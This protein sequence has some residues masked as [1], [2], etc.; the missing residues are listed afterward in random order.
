MRAT[1]PNDELTK[2]IADLQGERR[3]E[4]I[5]VGGLDADDVAR[6]VAARSVDAHANDMFTKTEGNP[7]YVEELVRH[8][9]ESGGVLDDD[10]VPDS[11]RDTIARRLLRLPDEARRLLGI[12]AVCGAEFRNATIA[13]AADVGIDAVDD[14]MEL[15][16]RSGVVEER[17][18]SVGEYG[19]SHTLIQTVLHDGLGAARR[20]R[21]HRRI[22]EALMETG[23][24]DGEIAR[25][26][27]AA[28]ADGSDPVPGTEAALP[29]RA[30]CSPSVHLTTR[31]RCCAAR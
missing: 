29:R 9:D 22:G 27:L 8:L 10:S 11:V 23:G 31:S 1:E 4:R 16:M 20:A 15:A 26:L 28:A 21:V 30:R 25:H 7:F 5:V 2:L 3:V 13:R 19:F 14:T 18:A 17:P 12:A 6:L 24:D